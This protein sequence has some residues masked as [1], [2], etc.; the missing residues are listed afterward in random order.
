MVEFPEIAYFISKDLLSKNS[1]EDV[2]EKIAVT[3][4]KFIK[5]DL[6]TIF[7][8]DDEL[9]KPGG[10]ELSDK[11]NCVKYYKE[12]QFIKKDFT[13]NMGEAI[14]GSVIENGEPIVI[15][16]LEENLTEVY[17]EVEKQFS[18]MRSLLSIPIFSGPLVLG[19]LNIYSED[20]HEFT[21]QEEEI[22]NFIA[23]L[24]GIFIYNSTLFENAN[25]LYLNQKQQNEKISTLLSMS[26]LV[27]SSLDL[28]NILSL[29]VD[30]LIEFTGTGGA[31]VYFADKEENKL[32]YEF[33]NCGKPEC[34]LYNSILH[35]YTYPN[36]QCIYLNEKFYQKL[37]DI[38][39]NN[40]NSSESLNYNFLRCDKSDVILSKCTK[41][42]YFKNLQFKLLKLYVRRKGKTYDAEIV[43][44]KNNNHNGDD[45]IIC[46]LD[47]AED[48]ENPSLSNSLPSSFFAD[49]GLCLDCLKNF[50]PI[51]KNFNENIFED[52]IKDKF[53]DSNKNNNSKTKDDCLKNLYAS[54]EVVIPLKTEK[55]FIGFIFLLND[56]IDKN[57]QK[58]NKKDER[59]IK[60]INIHSSNLTNLPDSLDFLSAVSDIIAVA[61]SNAESLNAVEEAHFETI[62]SM[63]EAIEARDEY[64][65]NH[66]DRLVEYA[67]SIAA[68]LGLNGIAIR[69]IK[70]GAVLHDV[71][72]I[73]I[74]DSVLNKPGKLTDEEYEEIKKHPEIGF[75]LLKKIK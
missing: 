66:G 69:D 26:N 13:L 30:K 16:N 47:N 21:E 52:I 37:S 5:S 12:N 17:Y 23:L 25:F 48:N 2:Y 10:P 35:C 57:L 29:S 24:G 68:K 67:T 4:S 31:A 20:I 71:G 32:C 33:F 42:N 40:V 74:R 28:S 72:K 55:N 39:E 49:A 9:I 62:N 19:A 51:V 27:S 6:I 44:N 73:G 3:A 8:V 75:N 41:C 36:F 64:T 54:T 53:E 58:E 65:K 14:I 7:I 70:Y 18:G 50:K 11:I 38:E 61:L 60:H 1:K 34:E 45:K 43:E 46:T 59:K 63:S 56:N 22:G 15:K